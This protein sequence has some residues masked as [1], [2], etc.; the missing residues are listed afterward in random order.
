MDSN[1]IK[2]VSLKDFLHIIFKRKMQILLFF[3][4][5]VGIVAVASFMSKPTYIATAKILVKL[6]RENLF[7]PTATD[8]RPILNKNILE[9]IN[10]EIEILKSKSLAAEVVASLGPTTIYPSLVDKGKKVSGILKTIKGGHEP[11]SLIDKAAFKL[12]KFFKVNWINDSNVIYLSFKHKDPKIAALILDNLVH[13]YFDHHLNVHSASESIGF[14][15]EQA[16]TLKKELGEA[17]IKLKAFKKFHNII[18]L[19]E[20]R[21]L[22]L[23]QKSDLRSSIN[24]SINQIAETKIRTRQLTQQL[25]MTRESIPQGKKI[26]RNPAL[27]NTLQA[28]L[29]ELEIREKELLDKYTKNSRLVKNV[30]AEIRIV[31]EK[32]ANQEKKQ[33][34]TNSYGLNIIYQRLKDEL[35]KNEAELKALEGKKESQGYQLKD[36]RERL[37]KFN[38]VELKLNQLN[39]EVYATKQ[40]YDLYLKKFEES[41][42]SSAMDKEMISNV[43]LIEP[44]KIPLEPFGQ[45]VFFNLSLSVLLGT[46]GGFG[47]AFFREYFDDNIETIEDV[48]DFLQLPVLAS[49][50]YS[51]Q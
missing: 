7:I 51:K 28:K 39:Q 25:A 42:I 47:L 26:D 31:K 27:I 48:E 37:E 49:I 4:A 10:N 11:L 23:K 20:E 29:V 19:T 32:L 24:K 41:R 2:R 35:L 12:Q 17:E 3:I 1:E 38:Q 9:Q 16:Q 34:D 44:V 13:F 18:S 15:Q 36:Y 43:K 33:H 46:F 50:P 40:N 21:S 5:T 6:G 30:R 45:K 8:M 14:F 22:F